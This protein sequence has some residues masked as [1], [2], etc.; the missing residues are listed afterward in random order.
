MI[1]QEIQSGKIDL[2]CFGDEGYI[3]RES[4]KIK[5]PDVSERTKA[6][7]RFRK[8][9]DP[10][11]LK[12]LEETEKNYP[13]IE[14]GDTVIT[15]KKT[16]INLSIDYNSG[17][18]KPIDNYK[19]RISKTFNLFPNSELKVSEFEKWD[20]KSKDTRC[21][22]VLVKK[23]E[24][25][26]GFFKFSLSNTEDEIIASTSKIKV[27]GGSGG[28]FI[29]V[30]DNMVY[31]LPI[32]S[33]SIGAIGVE[34][35]NI[36]TKKSFLAKSD[37]FEEIIVTKDSIYKK[38]S[39]KMDDIFN[40][41]MKI[42]ISMGKGF[43]KM[44][45]SMDDKEIATQMKEMPKMLEQNIGNLEMFK[46]MSPADLERLAKMSGNVSK[47]QLEQI[48]NF[49]EMIKK[50]E[51]SGMMNEMKKSMAMMKGQMEGIG[52]ENIDRMT[53]LTQETMKERKI[54]LDELTKTPEGKD[55][56]EILESPRNYKPLTKEFGA[57][58]VA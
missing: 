40:N 52:N 55:I 7:D 39:I 58:K 35:T 36:L 11:D 32:K 26:K 50:M 18:D 5:I 19:Q 24:L 45:P 46:Q 8:T 48:K 37:T 41:N 28:G 2:L 38:G 51:K 1:S 22:G 53:K 43:D 57:V 27:K 6:G 25:K 31:S 12:I 13:K 15:G 29:D 56:D 34:Y 14:D 17:K 42:L 54:K 16:K 49:P 4:K 44:M 21:Y 47:E 23:I 20:K 9:K 30:Y 3:K 10:K 33:T